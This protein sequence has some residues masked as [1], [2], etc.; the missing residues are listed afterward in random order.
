MLCSKPL[1]VMS[2]FG[3][4]NAPKWFDIQREAINKTTENFEHAVYLNNV[5][6]PCFRDCTV[7]GSS[8]SNED[9][10]IQ[11]Y[12]GL[13]NLL[14]YARSGDYRAWLVLDCDC[15]PIRS[16]WESILNNRNSS[17]VRTENLDTFY[18]PSA[19]YCSDCDLGFVVD[20][21]KNL[22]GEEFDE[23]RAV[24]SF[25]PLLRTNRVNYHPLK[26][27][28]YY[29]IFYHHCAGSR[30]FETRSDNYYKKNHEVNEYD[31]EFFKNPWLFIE[32]MTYAK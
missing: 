29:D 11:H 32:N 15:F 21:Q 20:K 4:E 23:L 30:K 5:K 7:V 2:V 26:Y 27:G 16:D 10:K 25:F 22:L 1:L 3:G 28:I 12:N 19:V 8:V 31:E 17:I 14:N 6:D 24:G 18:H 9:G 13:L